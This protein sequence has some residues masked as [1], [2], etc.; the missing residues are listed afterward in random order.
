MHTPIISSWNF[1]S[2]LAGTVGFSLTSTACATALRTL[3]DALDAG[4]ANPQRAIVSMRA[5]GDDFH[6]TTLV[7]TYE[8]KV[9]A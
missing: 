7:F 3:A 1:D 8:E 9:K 2:E 6:T 5:K 4:L